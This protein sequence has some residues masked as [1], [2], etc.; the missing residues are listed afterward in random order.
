MSS[1]WENIKIKKGLGGA[2][3]IS[4]EQKNLII[5]K[6]VSVWEKFGLS[7]EE[8]SF[9]AATMNLESGFNPN[10]KYPVN[11]YTASGLGQFTDATWYDAVREYNDKY[12]GASDPKI[13]PDVN[14]ADIDAQIKAMGAWISKVWDSALGFAENPLLN[15][16]TVPEIA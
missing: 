14:R 11:G 16:F 2:G 10:A 3:Q 8:I 4:E 5:D 6:T 13:F 9:G 7:K 1:L 12:R 15:N